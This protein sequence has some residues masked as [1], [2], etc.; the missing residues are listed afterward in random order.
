M[1]FQNTGAV[2]CRK[3]II[4]IIKKEF[5]HSEE[6]SVSGVDDLF[7]RELDTSGGEDV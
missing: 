2:T 7:H 4:V 1:I 6:Y 3:I 5:I